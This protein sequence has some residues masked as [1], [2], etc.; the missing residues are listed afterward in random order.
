[1]NNKIEMLCEAVK[2]IKL[3]VEGIP[4]KM[5]SVVLGEYYGM[6]E[7]IND[8]DLARFLMG[9]MYSDSKS[10]P[11]ILMVMKYLEEKSNGR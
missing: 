10:T 1:M 4:V 8:K 2:S 5:D 9:V 6:Y 11:Y 7:K 3:A